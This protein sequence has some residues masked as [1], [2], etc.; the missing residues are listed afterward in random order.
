MED[1]SAKDD[2]PQT[3]L[4]SVKSIEEALELL[5]ADKKLALTCLED[6]EENRLLD[7]A[8]IAP[9]GGQEL[10]LFQHLCK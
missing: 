8:F 7:K 10:F 4:P 5:E 2:V 3:V 9:W 1:L 6:I